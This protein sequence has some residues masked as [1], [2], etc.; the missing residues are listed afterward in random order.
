M[1]VPI[2]S[3]KILPKIAAV[4]AG[5][6]GIM[7]IFAGS[8][9]V[10]GIDTKPYTVLL[11]LVVYNVVMGFVSIAVTIRIWNVR[12]KSKNG[13]LFILVMH[14][15]VFI[16]LKF[17]Y[18]DVASESISAMIFRISSWIVISLLAIVIP[19]YFNKIK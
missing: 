9:V 7:S 4:I 18:V 11:G 17:V 14:L 10:L 12:K 16:Y 6:I 5:F 3:I 19:N 13:I 2:N 8:K 15:L 1:T